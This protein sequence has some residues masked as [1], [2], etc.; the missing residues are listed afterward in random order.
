[1]TEEGQ[2]GAAVVDSGSSVGSRDQREKT[3]EMESPVRTLG[4]KSG[5]K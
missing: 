4:G 5:Q 3:L 2:V 1:M